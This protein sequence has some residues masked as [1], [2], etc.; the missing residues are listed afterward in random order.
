[1]KKLEEDPPEVA[2]DPITKARLYC[3]AGKTDCTDMDD[4]KM[5]Q[6]PT[7]MVWEENN[8]S[9]TYYCTNGNADELG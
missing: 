4:S 8:L 3:A 2:A 5:C 6:C 1:M 7:C 9:A